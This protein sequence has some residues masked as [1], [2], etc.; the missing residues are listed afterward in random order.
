[1]TDT[2]KIVCYSSKE[3]SVGTMPEE[4]LGEVPRG[5]EMWTRTF[6]MVC[7]GRNR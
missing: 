3:E 5:E 7:M 6:I 4:P 2:E 1:M